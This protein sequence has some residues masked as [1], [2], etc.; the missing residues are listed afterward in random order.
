MSVHK[1]IQA[2]FKTNLQI[3]DK[4]RMKI[5][6]SMKCINTELPPFICMQQIPSTVWLLSPTT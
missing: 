1:N 4:L 2:F 6:A 3:E 5:L